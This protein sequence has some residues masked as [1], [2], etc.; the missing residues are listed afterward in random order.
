MEIRTT[1]WVRGLG[2]SGVNRGE[3]RQG[4]SRGLP[5]HL[6]QEETYI[7]IYIYIYISSIHIDPPFQPNPLI[8]CTQ[9]PKYATRHPP[10]S[11]ALNWL[12]V[13]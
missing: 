6:S 9:E 11:D 4:G 10:L 8:H 5:F 13:S 7:D 2:A 3:D 1:G 12:H